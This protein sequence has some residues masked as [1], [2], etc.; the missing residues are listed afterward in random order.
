MNTVVNTPEFTLHVYPEKKLVHHEMHRFVF[1]EPFHDLLM[2]G[3]ETF[4]K[5]G[6]TKW[7]S[8]DRGNSA[9][10]PEDVEW[11]QAVWEPRVLKAGWKYWAIV[12]PEKVIGQMSMKRLASRYAQKGLTVEVFSDPQK[13]MAWIERQ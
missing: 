10:R 8:D 2:K 11:A 7:L 4:E 3:A 1:G 6:C 5:H 13:A 9:T 12:L